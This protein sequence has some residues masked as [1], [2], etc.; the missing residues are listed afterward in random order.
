M[1][2]NNETEF[3]SEGR[4]CYARKRR[5][6]DKRDV[7]AFDKLVER[8]KKQIYQLAYQMT[9][10]HED[11]EDIS[12]ETFMQAYKS[13][14]KFKRKSKFSTRLYRIAINLSINHLKGESR[15]KHEV[16]DEEMLA[17]RGRFFSAKWTS[18]PMEVVE[19]EELGQ[20]IEEAIDSLPIG[21][22]VVFILRVQQGLSYKEI[23]KTLGCPIGTVMSRLNRA[24]GKLRDKLKAY[25]V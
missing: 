11:A 16:L 5:S 17:N 3:P 18:N 15:Y 6:P 12:Q 4:P 20:Q 8:Y 23:A 25:V 22:K 7:S 14:G 10:R 13:I 1:S 19:A 21:E 2:N 24:R 9:G